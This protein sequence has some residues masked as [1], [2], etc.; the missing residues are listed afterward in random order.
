MWPCAWPSPVPCLHASSLAES[1][2]HWQSKGI[3]CRF[4]SGGEHLPLKLY[5]G[6]WYPKLY[7]EGKLQ[8]VRYGRCQSP[9]TYKQQGDSTAE[10]PQPH[11][12]ECMQQPAGHCIQ[13]AATVSRLPSTISPDTRANN[14]GREQME[15]HGASAYHQHGLV[16][17]NIC[18]KER[19]R[20]W[21][22]QKKNSVLVKG[23]GVQIPFRNWRV[24]AVATE[25]HKP[26]NR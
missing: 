22:A 1:G 14:G 26:S 17:A 11:A 7:G 15:R 19:C 2:W 23:Q 25:K 3:L 21:S 18:S 4:V 10:L 24:L 20:F 9:H 6:A 13:G 5:S 12:M 16:Q 8:H